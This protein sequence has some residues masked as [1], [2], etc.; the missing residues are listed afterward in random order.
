[1]APVTRSSSAADLFRRPGSP[2][3]ATRLRAYVDILKSTDPRP[4]VTPAPPQRQERRGAPKAN[5]SPTLPLPGRVCPHCARP[6]MA[7]PP[8]RS[9]PL[10][11]SPR[12]SPPH[13]LAPDRRPGLLGLAPGWPHPLLPLASVHTP[14]P[15]PSRTP[16]PRPS[17]LPTRSPHR[18]PYRR[19]SNATRPSPRPSSSPPLQ[20]RPSPSYSQHQ[21]ELAPA[22]AVVPG[23][24]IRSHSLHHRGRQPCPSPPN[25][26]GHS[27]SEPNLPSRNGRRNALCGSCAG[28]FTSWG[29]RRHAPSCSRR[30]QAD[31][32][33]RRARHGVRIATTPMTQGPTAM[34]SPSSP[35]SRPP[36]HLGS[37]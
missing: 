22:T 35:P 29:L 21:G 37:P 24:P 27:P 4:T 15:L 13:P 18:R 30:C 26:P 34:G 31:A 25:L 7:T 1:M 20:F 23:Q 19:R 36:T 9:P 5:R 16:S 3:L 8:P 2:G 17:S 11:P 28:F 6:P 12:P 10:L 32:E 33:A 14:L